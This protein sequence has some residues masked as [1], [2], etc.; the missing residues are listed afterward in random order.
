MHKIW[1]NKAS[2]FKEAEEFDLKYYHN[3][4]SSKRLDIVQSLRDSYFKI[5]GISKDECKKRLRRI[6]KVIK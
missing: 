3:M 1:I 6:I 5:N 4:S 2:S